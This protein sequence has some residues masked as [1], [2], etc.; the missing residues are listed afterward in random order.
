MDSGFVAFDEI[1]D[2]EVSLDLC[3]LSVHRVASSSKTDSIERYYWKWCVIGAHAAL[4]TSLVL[5]LSGS[6]GVGALDDRS[7]SRMNSWLDQALAT[8]DGQVA[9]SM[10]KQPLLELSAL[11]ERVGSTDA[12]GHWGGQCI[13]LTDAEKVRIGRLHC[14]RNLFTHYRPHAWL[15]ENAELGSAVIE[16]L[17]LTEKLLSD[18]TPTELRSDEHRFS[19]IRTKIEDSRK[20][21]RPFAESDQAV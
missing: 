11:L 14:R 2:L 9:P 19:R 10:P 18:F 6:A 8:P 13:K 12:M 16:S 7:I 3:E 20:V 5:T 15:F 4:Q 21:L 1:C 17:S